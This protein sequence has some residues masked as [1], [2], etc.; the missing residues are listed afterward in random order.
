MNENKE[1]TI[2]CKWRVKT[3][4][5]PWGIDVVGTSRPVHHQRK[6][7]VSQ[8]RGKRTRR[9][10]EKGST[11]VDPVNSSS[12]GTVM[13]TEESLHLSKVWNRLDDP[14]CSGREANERFCRL[15]ERST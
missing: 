9:G 8:K 7:R 11:C 4:L 15:G 3:R 12:R 14:G 13:T 5:R 6:N 1:C 2:R 10:R